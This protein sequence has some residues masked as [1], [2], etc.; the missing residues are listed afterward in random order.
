MQ[1]LL[2]RN[3]LDVMHYEK[4]VWENILKTIFGIKD[5]VV[6]QEHL[7]ECRIQSHLWL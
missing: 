4:N 2:V 5:I 7:K 3:T 1:D 6:V